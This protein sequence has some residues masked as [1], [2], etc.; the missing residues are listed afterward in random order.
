MSGKQECHIDAKE[1]NRLQISGIVVG[2]YEELEA[3]EAVDH[4]FRSICARHH[5]LIQKPFKERQQR[6][7]VQHRHRLAWSRGR[8]RWGWSDEDRRL[9]RC[10]SGLAV[11]SDVRCDAVEAV[12]MSVLAGEGC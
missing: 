12:A 3:Q 6:R 7:C 4:G 11:A 10:G 9:S 2:G 8:W 5:R 1:S